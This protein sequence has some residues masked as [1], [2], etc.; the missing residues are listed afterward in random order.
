MTTRNVHSLPC[1]TSTTNENRFAAQYEA[2]RKIINIQYWQN[3][4]NFTF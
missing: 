4:Y 2:G 3:V 1:D